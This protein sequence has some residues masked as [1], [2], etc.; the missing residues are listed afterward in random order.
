MKMERTLKPNCVV[1]PRDYDEDNP[2]VTICNLMLG[3][4]LT[5]LKN[6]YIYIFYTLFLP[7]DD[8]NPRRV[9]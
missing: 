9:N 3:D 1:K 6:I 7:R 8:D 5:S 2:R 4:Q